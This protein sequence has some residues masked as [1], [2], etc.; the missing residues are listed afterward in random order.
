MAKPKYVI[1]LQLLN[2]PICCTIVSVLYNK[3]T[4]VM[5]LT[6]ELQYAA[7]KNSCNLYYY[8]NNG[9]HYSYVEGV[10]WGVKPVDT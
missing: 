7:V 4:Q 2:E 6:L 9:S 1:A 8:N 10:T 3:T 5:F